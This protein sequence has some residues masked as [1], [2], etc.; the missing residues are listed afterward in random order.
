MSRPDIVVIGGGPA[1]AAT[2]WH[3]A[4]AGAAVVLVDD[5]RVPWRSVGQQLSSSALARLRVLGV[6]DRLTAAS[7]AVHEARSSWAGPEVDHRSSLLSPYGPPWAVDRAALDEL[8]RGA[9][10]DAGARLVRARVGAAARPDGRWDVVGADGVDR[11][12][13]VVV[14]ATGAARAVSRGRLRW[15]AADRLRCTVWQARPA[16]PGPQPWSLVE[17]APDGWW[18]TAPSAAG[19]RL[20]VLQV[21]DTADRAVSVP[22]PRTTARLA[23]DPLPRPVA[24]RAAMVGCAGPPWRSGLVA[25]GDAA[26]CVDPLSSSGIRHALDLAAPAAAAAQGLL[27]GDREPAGVY[28]R[29]VHAAFGRHLSDRQQFHA[30]ATRYREAAFWSRRR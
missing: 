2:A 5:G 30:A 24:R 22:P 4:T 16:D 20:T 18:Y 28:E 13:P 21:Q 8:L 14:D 12:V 7:T 26:L 10:Q 11:P 1:G 27:D 15:H 29:L 19:E 3:L 23:A 9:A 25:V 17:A 6:A